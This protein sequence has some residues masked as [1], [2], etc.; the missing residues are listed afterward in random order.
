MTRARPSFTARLIALLLG[1]AFA[2][3]CLA[4]APTATGATLP[5]TLTPDSGPIARVNTSARAEASEIADEANVLQRDVARTMDGYARSFRGSLTKEEQ[6]VLG[7]YVTQAN[8]RMDDVVRETGRLERAAR[9][10]SLAATELARSRSQAAWARAQM[11]SEESFD[12]ARSIL[13]PHMSL[14]DRIEALA[15][16]TFLMN[17]FEDLGERID[18]LDLT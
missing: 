18:T 15:D 14:G 1:P 12:S 9:G 3:G 8:R 7:E 4:S 11:A 2:L 10:G 16:Y 5:P 13:E 6:R 17:R